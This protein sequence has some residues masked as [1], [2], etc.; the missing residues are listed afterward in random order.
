[1]WSTLARCLAQTVQIH[2]FRWD[3]LKARSS[4]L[5][6]CQRH[7]MVMWC[8]FNPSD[9]FLLAIFTQRAQFSAPAAALDFSS[10][11]HTA[12]KKIANH[13]M[14]ESKLLTWYSLNKR[15]HWLD[16]LQGFAWITNFIN[17][18][19]TIRNNNTSDN[20]KSLHLLK[21]KKEA[22]PTSYIRNMLYF[23]NFLCYLRRV[24]WIAERQ[25][26]QCN[27]KAIMSSL[28]TII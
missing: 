10:P 25:L 13:P 18:N 5:K 11:S 19:I 21:Y 8:S 16:N 28:K 7:S 24:N 6:H 17:H 22:L 2:I 27:G 26:I 4:Q 12:T 23:H 3:I 20:N 9:S 14:E 15:Y 1:M